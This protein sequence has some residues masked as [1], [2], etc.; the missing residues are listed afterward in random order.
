[1][2]SLL[3]TAALV[4]AGA[5]V[6]L[7]QSAPRTTAPS[8]SPSAERAKYRALLDQYCVGCH[9]GRTASP[10]NE[11]VNLESAS[12]DDLRV[13]LH[14]E[15]VIEQTAPMDLPRRPAGR[16]AHVSEHRGR[17][18]WWRAPEPGAP[19]EFPGKLNTRP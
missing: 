2:K 17:F 9:N 7:A 14:V 11:P 8:P 1:M 3:A 16:G 13:A 15:P 18:G 19:S 6:L 5:A 4:W 12:L 10:A